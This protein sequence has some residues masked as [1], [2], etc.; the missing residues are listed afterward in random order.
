MI[1]RTVETA[2]VGDSKSSS[3]HAIHSL[4]TFLFISI[5]F[6]QN[7]Y[8]ATDD[9]HAL[10]FIYY[11]QSHPLLPVILFLLLP[12]QS[13]F[14]IHSYVSSA[15]SLSFLII[16]PERGYSS[17]HLCA[18][19]VYVLSNRPIPFFVFIMLQLV[20]SF[21][22]YLHSFPLLPLFLH[23]RHVAI[24]DVLYNLY[25]DSILW[26][27]RHEPPLKVLQFIKLFSLSFFPSD[28]PTD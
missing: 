24:K 18:P 3:N 14:S 20:R 7:V 22:P 4:L 11:I 25:H 2:S 27:E 28:R 6:V 13:A 10:Q 19:F 12:V 26:E 9:S 15:R 8:P 17:A 16:P 21:H 5:F 23:V 1:Q